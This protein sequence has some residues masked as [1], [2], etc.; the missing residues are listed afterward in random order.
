[1]KNK[2]LE[3]VKKKKEF[4]G[5]PD[6]I[7]KQVISNF[8]NNL[9]E[10]EIIKEARAKLRK[11][12]GVFLTNKVVKPKNIENFEAIPKSHKSSSKRDYNKFYRK[13]LGNKKFDSIIDLGCGVNGFSF[14]YLVKENKSSRYIGVEASKVL[15]ENMNS[16]FESKNY[17][18]EAIW[19]NLL[20][21]ENVKNIITKAK[22]RKCIFCF[23]IIDA[24]EKI[25]I[26]SGS[27]F[28]KTLLEM[29]S[30][31]DLLIVSFPLNNLSG[32]RELAVKR[33]WIIHFL[34]KKTKFRD[35][36]MSG[37]KFFLIETL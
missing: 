36:F 11:Y 21:F 37:E 34:K 30:E 20:E 35:I 19:A 3:E 12:F 25:E 33:N 4:L 5:L 13:L 8:E 28:L 14:P 9:S 6:S 22:G 2:L 10:K 17:D 32:R 16:F 29:M 15:V 7:V 23:Q 24:L 31:K 1:M 18:A 27:S 26:G